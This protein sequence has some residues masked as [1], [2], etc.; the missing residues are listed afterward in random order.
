MFLKIRR[1]W[2]FE[3]PEELKRQMEAE[4]ALKEQK[5]REKAEKKKKQ[6]AAAATAEA[7]VA[8]EKMYLPTAPNGK[9]G[10]G[11]A[12]YS[13]WDDA[14]LPTHKADGSEVPKKKLKKLKKAMDGQKKRY[15]KWQKWYNFT[16]HR[17]DIT[18]RTYKTGGIFIKLFPSKQTPL[19]FIV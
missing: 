8:P 15:E 19:T 2:K 14:G 18:T 5:I 7:P 1:A 6:A 17:K 4:K 9:D 13:Q 3:N 10:D 16:K 12:L 11:N